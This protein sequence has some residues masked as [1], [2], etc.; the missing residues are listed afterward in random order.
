MAMARTPMGRQAGYG[1]FGGEYYDEAEENGALGV[2]VLWTGKTVETEYGNHSGVTRLVFT[3][4]SV[5]DL[6][7]QTCSNA[8]PGNLA[9]IRI[10]DGEILAR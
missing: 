4:G 8:G 1:P 10:R 3:D 5:A 9:I 7:D 6:H 2:A